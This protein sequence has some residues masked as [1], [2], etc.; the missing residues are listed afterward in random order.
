M[1]ILLS[2]SEYCIFFLLELGSNTAINVESSVFGKQYTLHQTC[3]FFRHNEGMTNHLKCPQD[4]K[5]KGA[6]VVS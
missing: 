6:V 2:R 3:I 1:D 5:L 4:S